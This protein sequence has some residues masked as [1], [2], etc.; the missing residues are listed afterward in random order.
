MNYLL[1]P[2]YNNCSEYHKFF[3]KEDKKLGFKLLELLLNC[4]FPQAFCDELLFQSRRQWFIFIDLLNNKSHGLWP[5]GGFSSLS[6]EQVV[7]YYSQRHLA[8]WNAIYIL[9]R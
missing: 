7:P 3:K 9:H 5:L 8:D 4:I 2:S 1:C 6:S